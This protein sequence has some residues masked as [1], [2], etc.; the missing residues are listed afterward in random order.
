M[1][2][3]TGESSS[4]VLSCQDKQHFLY[5]FV[6]PKR[7]TDRQLVKGTFS[8]FANV[9]GLSFA[10]SEERRQCLSSVAFSSCAPSELFLSGVKTLDAPHGHTELPLGQRFLGS[11]LMNSKNGIY[12]E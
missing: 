4:E 2:A 5:T 6:L 8:V 9:G 12:R 11:C 7:E 1:S 3:S 10:D